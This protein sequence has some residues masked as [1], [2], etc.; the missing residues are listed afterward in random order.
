[1]TNPQTSIQELQ[2]IRKEAENKIASFI[3]KTLTEFE[4]NTGIDNYDFFVE[5]TTF[6]IKSSSSPLSSINVTIKAQL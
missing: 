5:R 4:E 2:K 1:M 3:C 6:E